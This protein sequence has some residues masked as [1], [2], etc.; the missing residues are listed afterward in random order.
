[1]N[2]DEKYRLLPMSEELRAPIKNFPKDLRNQLMEVLIEHTELWF[3]VNFDALHRNGFMYLRVTL[4]TGDRPLHLQLREDG[5]TLMFDAPVLVDFPRRASYYVL[6]KFG[7]SS[8]IL[9]FGV[10]QND[11]RKG[12]GDDDGKLSSYRTDV[13]YGWGGFEFEAFVRSADVYLPF[14]VARLTEVEKELRAYLEESPS[15]ES[16]VA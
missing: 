1:M 7:A 12:E 8:P 16:L 14:L 5:G 10:I 9:N 4:D 6:S 13:L 2:I 15:V 11:V 3:D